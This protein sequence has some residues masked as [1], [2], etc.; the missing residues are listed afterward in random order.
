MEDSTPMK[1]TISAPTTDDSGIPT[2]SK[3][4]A[5][6]DALLPISIVGGLLGMLAGTLPAAVWVLIFGRSF[7]PMYTFLPLLIFLGIWV[8]KGCRDKRGFILACFLSA[9]GFYLTVLSCQAALD[10]IKYKMLFTNLPLVTATLIGSG[11]AF[12]GPTFSSAYLFPTLFTILG[13]LLVYE[14]MKHKPE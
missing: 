2:G 12:A 4:S 1:E 3:Q 14:L 13:V 5:K 7:A 8:F 9:I 10:V 11:E 6:Q